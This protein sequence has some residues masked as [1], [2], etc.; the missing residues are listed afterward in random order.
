MSTTLKS[1]EQQLLAGFPWGDDVPSML[2][3][4]EALLSCRAPEAA[5]TVLNQ[6]VP[7]QG[8]EQEAWLRLRWRAAHDAGDHHQALEELQRLGGGRLEGLGDVTLTATGTAQPRQALSQAVDHLIAVG[9]QTKAAALLHKAAATRPI[10]GEDLL[11]TAEILPPANSQRMALL[12]MALVNAAAAGHWQLAMQTLA[13]QLA[14]AL[15]QGDH[16]Q[17]HLS[18][19][20]LGIL[21]VE[22]GDRHHER[23]GLQAELALTSHQ[24]RH[25][26]RLLSRQLELEGHFGR[27]LDGLLQHLAQAEAAE[28]M[29]VRRMHLDAA[30]RLAVRIGH[31]FHRRQVQQQLGEASV[32]VAAPLYDFWRQHL[33]SQEAT[34]E[35]SVDGAWDAAIAQARRDNLPGVE[36]ELIRARLHR[37]IAVS[38]A[39]GRWKRWQALVQQLTG[40]ITSRSEADLLLHNTTK[41]DHQRQP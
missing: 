14:D 8:P 35:V 33:E 22:A 28:G 34:G 1:L 29:P 16:H 30:E 21:G 11:R 4:A 3:R 40:P 12:E 26:Y 7:G 39:P 38:S 18:A 41:P 31:S 25:T 6:V 37:S 9:A 27:D 23:M 24:P 15:E 13:L 36:L 32:D 5:Q 10:P 2:R 19:Q 20:Q 17:A